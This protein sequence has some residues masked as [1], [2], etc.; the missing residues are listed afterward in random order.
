[1]GA[2]LKPPPHTI[3]QVDKEF[4]DAGHLLRN[5]D[6]FLAVGEWPDQNY[7]EIPQQTAE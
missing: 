6:G 4:P 7:P 3:R 5:C 1:M 2:A